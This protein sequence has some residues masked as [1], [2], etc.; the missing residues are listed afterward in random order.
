MRDSRDGV[1]VK[2]NITCTHYWMIEPH[3][4]PTSLGVCRLCG[5]EREFNNYLENQPAVLE[6]RRDESGDH[7]YKYL[8]EA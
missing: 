6:L 5:A 2:V 8:V 3:L 1:N 7:Q 4:G